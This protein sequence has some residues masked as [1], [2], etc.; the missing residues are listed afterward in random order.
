MH[1]QTLKQS[2]LEAQIAAFDTL[3]SDL[4]DID[5]QDSSG[6]K[7][8]HFRGMLGAYSGMRKI[9]QEKLDALLAFNSSSEAIFAD[10]SH[11]ANALQ[12]GIDQTTTAWNPQKGVFTAPARLEWMDVIDEIVLS[13][14]TKTMA[15]EY[16]LSEEA[17][18]DLFPFY[19]QYGFTERTVYH[20]YLV[21]RELISSSLRSLRST[22]IT[23]F[24][25]SWVVL[26]TGR[27]RIGLMSS[28]G[29]RPLGI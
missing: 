6:E 9:L 11:L 29:I 27:R 25:G 13:I 19:D 4:E 7:A 24:C 14:F 17:A 5:D 10:I 15:T 20:L 22:V 21:A 26:S 2:E 8:L 28:S 3:I 18:A 23:F 1:T 12:T 16:G